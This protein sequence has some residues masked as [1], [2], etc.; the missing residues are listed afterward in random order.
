MEELYQI[1][2]LQLESKL[3]LLKD[4]PEETIESTIR[5]LWNK[6]HGHPLSAEKAI[7][8]PLAKLSDQQKN[9]LLQLVEKRLNGEPLAHLTGRQSFMGIELLCDNRTLIPRKETEILGK[10][11][12]KLCQ[13]FAIKKAVIKVFDMCCGSGNLGLALA[14]LHQN[15]LILSSD[16]SN[17]AIELTSENIS[18]LSLN[19]RVKVFQS[20]LFSKFEST[21]YWG[22]IDLIVCNPPYISTSKVSKMTREIA[23]NEPA[24]AFDGGMVGLKIIQKLIQESPKFLSKGGWLIFEVGIGQGHFVLQVC[25]KSGLYELVTS[26]TD[27][28]GNIR[29]IAACV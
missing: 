5:A 7:E 12:L 18:F 21:D 9:T 10:F 3:T 6:A 17:K 8:L 13:E 27:D 14:S 25:E 23:S 24:M 2:K 26:E 1:I 15:T 28:L 20:D 22:K 4:K 29:V 11:A 16:L 19:H